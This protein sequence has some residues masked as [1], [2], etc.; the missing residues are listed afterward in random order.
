[1]KH[2]RLNAGHAARPGETTSHWLR[3]KPLVLKDLR[4]TLRDTRT[5]GTLFL[6]PILVYP[7]ISLLMQ[8]FLPRSLPESQLSGFEIAFDSPDT[9]ATVEAGLTAADRSLRQE[10]QLARASLPGDSDRQSSGGG[11]KPPITGSQESPSLRNKSELGGI[12]GST[13]PEDLLLEQHNWTVIESDS[14]FEELVSQGYVDVIVCRRSKSVAGQESDSPSSTD[15]TERYSD[16]MVLELIYDP[17]RDLS[18]RAMNY[19]TLR[20]ERYNLMRLHTETAALATSPIEMIARVETAV[21]PV[22]SA[23][24]SFATIVPLILIMM[25]ITGAVYPAIDLTAGERERGTMESLMAAPVSRVAILAAKYVAVWIVAMLTATLNVASMLT[26]LWVLQLDKAFLGEQGITVSIVVQIFG[27]LGLFAI[28]F[29]SILL[30]VTSSARSFKEAQA[31]LIPLMMISLTPGALAMMPDLESSL[32][33]ALVPMVNL[34]LLARDVMLGTAQSDFAWIAVVS[35]LLYAAAALGIAASIFGSDAVLYGSQTSWR[36]LLRPQPNQQVPSPAFSFLLL[37]ILFPVQFL[38]L[39]ILGRMQSESS[40]LTMIV[41]MTGFTALMFAG[42]PLA[43]VYWRG[44][45]WKKTLGWHRPSG[46]ALLS[47]ALLGASLWPFVGLS[48][49]SLSQL[50]R[51][52]WGT[53]SNGWTEHVVQ[54]AQQQLGGWNEIPTWLLVICLAIVPAVSEEI[55]FRGILLRSLQQKNSDLIAIVVSGIAFGLFHFIV[56]SSVAPLRLIVSSGLGM[57]LGWV[58]VK[59]GS[60]FPSILLHS[61]NNGIL[62]TVALTRDKLAANPEPA[63]VLGVLVAC[64]VG[65]WLGVRLLRRVPQRPMP[66]AAATGILIVAWAGMT[67]FLGGAC[68]G[69]SQCRASETSSQATQG[70][71]ATVAEGFRLESLTEPNLAADIHVLAIGPENEVFVGGPGYVARLLDENN[72]GKFESL[73]NP[74]F[75]PQ[76]APQGLWIES[77]SAWVVA[78]QAI[79]RVPRD[80]R[81]PQKWLSLPKTGGEHDFHAI[82]RGADG[83]LYFLAGNYA[84]ID[85]DFVEQAPPI[86]QP[87]DGVL[88]RISPDGQ[89]RQVLVHG[90]RNAYGFD[91]GLDQSL[92]IYDS[93][94][95]RDSGLPWYR[96]TTLFAANEGDD[97]GWVSRCF[98]HPE[99][100]LASPHILAETGRGSPTGVACQTTGAWGPDNFCG[101]AF[102][103]W[104]FGRIYWQGIRD[105]DVESPPVILVEGTPQRPLAPTSLAF[106]RQGRLLFATGGRQTSGEVFAIVRQ[107]PAQNLDQFSDLQTAFQPVVDWFAEIERFASNLAQQPWTP[108]SQDSISIHLQELKQRLANPGL[109]NL[110]PSRLLAWE[111]AGRRALI[112]TVCLQVTQGLTATGSREELENTFSKLSDLVAKHSPESTAEAPLWMIMGANVRRSTPLEPRWLSASPKG[113]A[114]LPPRVILQDLQSGREKLNDHPLDSA[115]RSGLQALAYTTDTFEPD[116]ADWK[117]IG[118]YFQN[119]LQQATR[120]GQ[121]TLPWGD[122]L[123][124]WRALCDSPSSS[125]ASTGPWDFMLKKRDADFSEAI[126]VDLHASWDKLWRRVAR[127]DADFMSTSIQNDLSHLLEIQ[128]LLS[129]RTDTLPERWWIWFQSIGGVPVPGSGADNSVRDR[130]GWDPISKFRAMVLLAACPKPWTIAMDQQAIDFL[131]NLDRQLDRYDVSTDRNWHSRFSEVGRLLCLDHPRLQRALADSDSWERPGQIAILEFLPVSMQTKAVGKL[132]GHWHTWDPLPLTA[133]QLDT[134]A[135]AVAKWQL[136]PRIS[137]DY[138]ALVDQTD[139]WIRQT[140]ATQSRSFSRSVDERLDPNHVMTATEI[141]TSVD[142]ANG[143]PQ[144]GQQIFE[145]QQCRTCHEVSG[146]LGPSLAG[147]SRRFPRN[148]IISLIL[149]PD[150]RV[151]DRYRPLW[152]QLRDGRVVM[153]RPV[154]ESKDGLLLEDGDGKLWQWTKAEIEFTQPAQRSLMPTGLMRDAPAE[155][156]ADLWAYL[157]SL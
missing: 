118:E 115:A 5:I 108:T 103:D 145:Q 119:D 4:E 19:L 34:V 128:L 109:A 96:P 44:Y 20:L 144:R 32:G 110:D 134:L 104:T 99:N 120:T 94:D 13:A 143:N 127:G 82:R 15:A 77:D 51:W 156:W 3:W 39:G 151:T 101:V 87:R 78:D 49:W 90:M 8:N 92:L 42:I 100:R 142:W 31:Y 130:R 58:C 59:S 37:A 33:L 28:F 64:L 63:W 117:L 72:D 135:D 107:E 61:V 152:V 2:D 116:A 38:V 155:D 23:L 97:I 114:L 69:S 106:D 68:G 95:E 50:R 66:Q 9:F 27:L 121:P 14:S 41:S 65:V 52:L 140:R 111:R 89:I 67:G 18:R 124:I 86:R 154:Y 136:N 98:K 21:E 112:R 73:D 43:G 139:Q 48:L 56:E 153:G 150:Q 70:D 133:D 22:A 80:G 129:F 147:V 71:H 85:R 60:L 40:A 141:E 131:L 132:A 105:S 36:E 102:A 75:R 83:F 25:T 16:E 148:Q 53:D 125:D 88:G 55:L 126:A 12:F 29:S 7:L 157:L 6:M 54:L 93:D 113:L 122:W 1:V 17:S 149:N 46:T 11:R 138:Q 76:Q 45:Q 84:Q 62:T 26:T 47:G 91:F 30:V 123:M 10:M 79:W 81:T 57:V 24:V 74:I 146:R 137:N 35:T